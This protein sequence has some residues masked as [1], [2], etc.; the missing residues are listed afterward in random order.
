MFDVS[1][2]DI[3]VQGTD[4]ALSSLTKD[5]VRA[6]VDLTGLSE[7][8]HVVPVNVTL[9]EGLELVENVSVSVTLSKTRT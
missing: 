9:P 3:K 8:S 6:T 1:K 7:G 5:A 4:Q 2:V